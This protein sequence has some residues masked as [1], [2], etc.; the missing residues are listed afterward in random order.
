MIIL[1]LISSIISNQYIIY[2]N[3][4][5]N[6]LYNEVQKAEIIA[7]IE[8]EPIEK[9]YNITYKIKVQKVNNNEKYKNTYLILQVK[10]QEENKTYK[11]GSLVKINGE[12][13]PP[14]EQRNYKGFDYKEYLKTQ[15][16]YGTISASQNNIK[17]LKENS[18]SYVFLLANQTREKIIQISYK[19]LP[20]KTANLFTGILIGYKDYIQEDIIEN[21]KISSLSHIL[22][23]SGAHIS[24]LIIRNS[25]N[26]SKNTSSKAKSKYNYNN[27]NYSIY[28]YNRI[29]T[30][31]C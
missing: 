20:E 31:C 13:K 18:I 10:K 1:L 15:K 28:V 12:L 9:E 22:A 11:Y 8:S 27:I 19:I 17:T 16:T 2:L 30:I 26:V 25:I 29:Y 6:T 14:M 23:V 5:Y 24:Y 3:N 7:T 21:F 4:K